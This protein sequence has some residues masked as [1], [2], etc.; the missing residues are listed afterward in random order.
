[1]LNP[2]S[3]E[4]AVWLC[5]AVIIG[6]PFFF[7]TWLD[8]TRPIFA[9]A[10]Q[11]KTSL[12]SMIIFVALF[13]GGFAFKSASSSLGGALLFAS[14]IS[15]SIL[16]QIAG[17]YQQTMNRARPESLV[18]HQA[19]L[20]QTAGRFAV[21]AALCAIL[22]KFSLAI[23]FL[24]FAIP[25]LM[26]LFIR[27]QHRCTPMA[28]SSLKNGIVESFKNEGVLLTN[29][30][31][32]DDPNSTIKNAFIAGTGFGA[33]PFGRTLFITLGLFQTLNADELKAVMLHE[34]AHL[35]LNHASKRILSAIFLMVVSAFWITLPVTFLFHGNILAVVASVFACLGL[36][37]ALF[38]RVVSRQEHEADLA[39]IAMGA[40]SDAL[41][42]ALQKLT[43][44][45]EEI[46]N[47]LL[48]LMNGNLYPTVR[49][50]IDSV[51]SC[52]VPARLNPFSKAPAF[53]YS[54][55]VVGVVFWAAEHSV[56]P[57]KVSHSVEAIAGR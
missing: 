42:S 56:G 20:R 18:S 54:L 36:H 43:A 21:G 41:V 38:S 15:F 40:S 46:E 19:T 8:H 29:I 11:K 6:A 52:E 47:P 4:L 12:L 2:N 13:T 28:D 44:D 27:L 5:L 53:A 23:F 35:K 32:V 10:V 34:A 45:R 17:R 9:E 7:K 26:P 48:R 55:L 14:V 1:M 24:P 3:N 50:R 30:V 25:F 33:G 22:A 16:F 39:A 49:A 31:I 57:A 37:A 51:R